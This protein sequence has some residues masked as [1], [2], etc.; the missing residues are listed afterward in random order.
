[1]NFRSP[2]T[3]LLFAALL[4]LLVAG[5]PSASRSAAPPV[6]TVRASVL[7]RYP[8]DPR[9]FTQGLAVADG[10]LYE[11]TGWYG[12]SSLRRVDL[13]TGSILQLEMLPPDVFG[14]GITVVGDRIVQ[15]TWTSHLGYVRD[16][17]SFAQIGTF[18]YPTEG[19]GIA[20]D[21][22]R[23][24]M[25]DGSATLYFLD[26]DTQVEVG[27]VE[28]QADGRPVTR[29]NELEYVDGSV[30]ANVWGSDQI[31]V[32]DPGS[33]DVRYW[34]DLSGLNPG[35]VTSPDDVL[36]GIAYDAEQGRLLVT[37]KRWPMLYEIAVTPPAD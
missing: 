37:G 23:L 9:A 25:S 35:P 1:M 24:I 26:P 6:P 4:T 31:A 2:V 30:L 7:A 16:R 10:S 12:E 17:A 22:N 28:V 21:G 36:N 20:F 29:L 15:L 3:P 27:R 11:G 5:A 33:G 19:W 34:I 8:H 32:V 13:S 18:G 14:E